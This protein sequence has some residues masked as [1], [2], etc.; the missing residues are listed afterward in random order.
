MERTLRKILISGRER[1]TTL[2][3]NAREVQRATPF[4]RS[5]LN[6]GITLAAL[7]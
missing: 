5:A 3:I 6:T 1:E 4:A 2:N 7:L